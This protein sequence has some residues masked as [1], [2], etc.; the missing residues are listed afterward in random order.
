MAE[1]PHSSAIL[2]TLH[3][4]VDPAGPRTAPLANGHARLTSHLGISNRKCAVSHSRSK[5]SNYNRMGSLLVLVPAQGATVCHVTCD[6]LTF[7]PAWWLAPL[8]FQC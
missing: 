1:D 7:E 3:V 2:Q 5:R 6:T 4:A 8:T